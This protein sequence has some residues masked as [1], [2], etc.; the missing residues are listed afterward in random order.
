MKQ[1]KKQFIVHVIVLMAWAMTMF[2]NPAM[3]QSGLNKAL[4]KAK[5]NAES[6]TGKNEGKDSGKKTESANTAINKNIE[7]TTVVSSQTMASLQTYEWGDEVE[8]KLD[9]VDG[10]EDDHWVK[11]AV[12][13]VKDNTYKIVAAKPSGESID[14]WVTADRLRKAPPKEVYRLREELKELKEKIGLGSLDDYTFSL[15][16]DRAKERID[17][18]KES[19]PNYDIKPQQVAWSTVRKEF[20]QMKSGVAD[21]SKKV[22]KK[23]TAEDNEND[24][25]KW[26]YPYNEFMRDINTFKDEVDKSGGK[27]LYDFS[28][29]REEKNGR[30]EVWMK[31]IYNKS[32]NEEWVSRWFSDL[33]HPMSVKTF[34]AL[35]GLK[36]AIDRV[37][38][39]EK[40]IVLDEFLKKQIDF[41]ANTQKSIDQWDG[42]LPLYRKY[43]QEEGCIQ[44]AVDESD[45]KDW[46]E[47]TFYRWLF[48][49]DKINQMM[50]DLKKSVNAKG[51]INKV[52]NP[53]TDVA[54]L[55]HLDNILEAHKLVSEYNPSTKIWIAHNDVIE[56]AVSKK[57][58]DE[59]IAKWGYNEEAKNQL[60]Y[61]LNTLETV[62]KTKIP[63]NKPKDDYF[64]FHNAADESMIKSKIGDLS[65][66][67][68]HKIGLSNQEWLYEKNDLG[69]PINRY[70][71][72]FVWVTNT[73][74]DYP[75]GHL[76]QVSL[77][78][79]YAGGGTYGATYTIFANDW[80]VARP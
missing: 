52:I 48:Y 55:S 30:A 1:N 27:P 18:I 74:D 57:V 56:R 54:L 39:P 8:L 51:G 7:K 33:E 64:T 14:I 69:I 13:A 10:S 28:G 61:Y 78:Q 37:G 53:I 16:F 68:I 70:K 36:Q 46:I 25:T 35:N 65:K 23:Y 66:I 12:D 71:R 77:I 4:K 73:A 26:T 24:W 79:D 3:S 72:G 76:Y 58:R 34:A 21:G 22:K 19:F 5:K 38:G 40:L 9:G 47:K 60:T 49:Q 32:E 50:D 17:R 31:R 6:T 41:I 62:C 67:K 29:T 75:Y 44:A 80:I 43:S 11:G 2:W 42:A 63:L 15:Y 45:R 20:E 59:F